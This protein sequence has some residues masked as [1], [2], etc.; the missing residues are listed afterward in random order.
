MV[1][2]VYAKTRSEEDIL[3]HQE[4]VVNQLE[5][6]RKSMSGVSLEEEAIDLMKYQTVFNAS[7]KVLKVGDELLQTVLSLRP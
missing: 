7:A 6:Y 4:A 1:W 3:K 5:E 2:F